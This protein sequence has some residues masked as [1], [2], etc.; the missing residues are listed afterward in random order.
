MISSNFQQQTFHSLW[1]PKLSLA[2]TS[3]SFLTTSTQP[4][5][6]S[7]YIMIISQLASVSVS[8]TH[9]QPK[10][11]SY[12]CQTVA[13]LQMWGTL[14]DE[15]IGLLFT[16][17]ADPRQQSF[18]SLSPTKL[19]TRVYCVRFVA[20]PTWKVRSRYLYILGTGLPNYITRHLVHFLSPP[21]SHRTTAELSELTSTQSSQTNVWIGVRVP[22][23]LVIHQQCLALEAHN[24]DLGWGE[25]G[26]TGTLAVTVLI[27]RPLW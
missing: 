18:W 13:S 17:I 2:V 25:R 1:V 3:F 22:S 27:Q 20:P 7:K 21:T 9:L 24:Q 16:V 26:A 10:T 19:M 5:S 12:Y 4:T 11:S 23:W 8:S 15:M 6:Q 14:P